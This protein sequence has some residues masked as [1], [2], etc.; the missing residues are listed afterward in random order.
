[1]LLLSVV[2][3]DHPHGGGK[4]ASIQPVRDVAL[5]R[6]GN[7]HRSRST[8]Y[9]AQIAPYS[10]FELHPHR[11][12]GQRGEAAHGRYSE[13]A[14]GEDRGEREHRVLQPAGGVAAIIRS[15]RAAIARHLLSDPENPHGSLDEIARASGFANAGSLRRALLDIYEVS[16]SQLRAVPADEEDGPGEHSERIGALFDAPEA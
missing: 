13:D 2:R 5:I 15:R 1:M 6:L 12:I 16:P 3:A 10:A 4:P 9:E 14:A 8:P 11:A 7:L